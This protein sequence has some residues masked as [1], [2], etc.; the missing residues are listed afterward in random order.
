MSLLTLVKPILNRPDS[1]EDVKLINALTAIEAWANGQ[2]DTGN[3]SATAGIT[4]GQL[5][6]A[7]KALLNAKVSGL[8]FVLHEA[9]GE[10]KAGEL[11]ACNKGLTA[12]LPKATASTALGVWN[13]GAEPVK[14]KC[15]AGDSM[16]GRF[17]SGATE[18]T[19]LTN[20]WIIVLGDPTKAW[21]IT[22]GEPKREQKYTLLGGKG[23]T[24]GELEAGQTV[25]A[26]RPAMVTITTLLGGA[27]GNF[28]YTVGGEKTGV[29]G[30]AAGS[31]IPISVL[32]FPGEEIKLEGGSEVTAAEIYY[33]LL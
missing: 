5:A 23:L 7:V 25:S 15:A 1:T 26:T 10:V 12:T 4:E 18:V 33:R 16:F 17:I 13:Y 20:Q 2:I 27:G 3:L 11:F 21:L 9:S 22:G 24:K 8:Q 31:R 28:Q 6:A 32:V 14:V 19:L 29:P 30:G